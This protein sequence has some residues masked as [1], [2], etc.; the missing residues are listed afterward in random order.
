MNNIT[1]IG[2]GHVGLVTGVTL[3]EIGHHIVC[4]DTDETNILKMRAGIS[5]FFEPGLDELLMKNA[6]LGRLG[7][8]NNP[9]QA[10]SEANIIYIAVGTP[11]LSSG[12]VD[13]SSIEEVA[14]VIGENVEREEIIIVTKS[15]VP[16]GTN[17]MIK[18]II[19]SNS[20]SNVKVEMVSNPEF[21][22]EGTAIHDSFSADRIVI[23]SDTAH[24]AAIVED[25]YSPLGVPIFKTDLKSAEM[26]KYSANAFLA[27]KISFINEIA[28]LCEKAGANI[29]EVSIGMGLDTRIG[30]QFLQAGIGYGGACLPKDTIAL[31][32]TAT[33]FGENLE[34]LDSAIKVNNQQISRLINKAKQRFGRLQ[35][36][37]VALLG[38]SFKPNTND[39]RNSL[40]I[41]IAKDL[42]NMGVVL[43]TYDPAA[44]DDTKLALGNTIHYASSIEEAIKGKDMVFI[45]TD[46]QEF[47]DFPIKQYVELM[48]HPIIFDGRN[49][50]PL[51][52][53]AMYNLEYYS[54]G[55][56]AI[57]NSVTKV[58]N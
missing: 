34:I 29:E 12:A 16:V 20:L 8:T 38:S 22:K 33:K 6:S 21:L 3:A 7:F 35:G 2:A 48:E 52:K 17:D 27:T 43:T 24:T 31:K 50:Y 57:V 56:Q 14:R 4:Y 54:I 44:L 5:P 9:K 42:T 18:Q 23:G 51:G 40:A 39:V 36:K 37:K 11:P 26:I 30:T 45:A 32:H 58:N 10:L 49:C 1:I 46:W 25:L 28:N 19:V 13:L 41:A 15:T 53:V 47:K 55:R